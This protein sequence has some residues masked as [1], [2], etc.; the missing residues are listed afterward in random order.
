MFHDQDDAI[1]KVLLNGAF[2]DGRKL[3]TSY[4]TK[5]KRRNQRK[6]QFKALYR[7]LQ[8]KKVIRK[9]YLYDKTLGR[10]AVGSVPYGSSAAAASARRKYVKSYE[11]NNQTISLLTEITFY[12]CE[13]QTRSCIGQVHNGRPFYRYLGRNTPPCCMEKLKAVFRHV[14]DEFENV[15]IRY[16]LDNRALRDAIELK[17]LSPDA[18]EIDLSF[19]GDDVQR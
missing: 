17:A 9:N 19:N 15:G 2:Q 1:H 18:Y 8:V 7:R 5:T 11:H 3:F 10:G 4:H 13:K 12:G 6:E 14:V 16:W